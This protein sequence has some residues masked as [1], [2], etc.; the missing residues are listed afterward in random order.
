MLKRPFDLDQLEADI[1]AAGKNGQA[2]IDEAQAL[3]R[4]RCEIE[5]AILSG[6]FSNASLV[7]T[8]PNSR[9]E[10]LLNEGHTRQRD[11]RRAFMATVRPALVT[12]HEDQIALVDETGRAFI[13]ALK[14]LLSFEERTL[15]LEYFGAN[16]RLTTILMKE[17]PALFEG[18]QRSAKPATPVIVATPRPRLSD[19]LRALLG[20][21]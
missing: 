2:L 4:K 16:I 14:S 21:A 9:I 7:E 1:W 10:A 19:A 15:D 13:A 12:A 5:S 17:L 20:G 18:W 6:A 8:T 11:D 3:N